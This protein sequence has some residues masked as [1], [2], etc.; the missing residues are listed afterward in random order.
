M[1]GQDV[2]AGDF[3]VISNDESTHSLYEIVDVQGSC[4]KIRKNV[5]VEEEQ[6][7]SNV[8]FK[9]GE[10]RVGYLVKALDAGSYY[11]G[12]LAVY[13]FYSL[14]S[15]SG[16]GG[17][18]H[19]GRAVIASSLYFPMR[20]LVKPSDQFRRGRG[21][22]PLSWKRAASGDELVRYSIQLYVWLMLGG[23]HGDQNQMDSIRSEVSKWKDRV[24]ESLGKPADDMDALV[25]QFS[26]EDGLASYHE[27]GEEVLGALK[28]NEKV[29]EEVARSYIG[30]R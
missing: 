13:L 11:G 2:K 6:G 18:G 27:R 26:E 17:V 15:G 1:P 14:F 10:D 22:W 7:N 21:G 25:F 30:G 24:A 3:L 4:L 5:A 20:N 28:F 23:F 16:N 29:W 12:M 8:K 19:F 9:P